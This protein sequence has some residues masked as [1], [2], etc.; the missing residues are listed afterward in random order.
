MK[1]KKTVYLQINTLRRI[2]FNSTSETE[3]VAKAIKQYQKNV[4]I[5]VSN[6]SA[7][8]MFSLSFGYCM[9]IFT[10]CIAEQSRWSIVSTA[11][12][13]ECGVKL[14]TALVYRQREKTINTYKFKRWAQF[15]PYESIKRSNKKKMC[16]FYVKVWLVQPLENNYLVTIK[17]RSILFLLWFV[18][19]FMTNSKQK[20]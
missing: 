6:K 12:L 9:P 3:T 1:S 13:C 11:L 17:I 10:T 16:D 20:H 15:V 4:N 2:L 5:I 14:W 8:K 7:K 19:A 18:T